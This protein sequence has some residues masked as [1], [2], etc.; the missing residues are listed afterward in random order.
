MH[1]QGPQAPGWR[2]LRPAFLLLLYGCLLALGHWG[3]EWLIS[4]IGAD[5]GSALKSHAE[6]VVIAGIALY[7]VLMAIP[8]V[9]GMEISLSLFAVFGHQVAVLVYAATVA[10]LATSYLIGRLVPVRFLASVFSYFRMN[11]ASAL[12]DKLEPLDAGQRL[13]VLIERAPRQMVPLLL[14]HRYITIAVAFNL[15]G[16][17][18]IGGG[19]GI[20]LLA[21]TSGLFTFPRYLLT[22]SL[23]VLPVPLV[24]LLA[25]SWN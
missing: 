7:A 11:R 6:H 22:M 15:P 23:A 21:G 2:W 18:I 14:K 9:P 13:D 10:A 24:I 3:S 17:A 20:A 8:F 12:I 5:L 1:P 4:V 19:G 16:N 25:G